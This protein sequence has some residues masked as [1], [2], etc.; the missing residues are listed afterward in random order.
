MDSDF[1]FPDS[2][3]TSFIVVILMTEGKSLDANVSLVENNARVGAMIACAYAPLAKQFKQEQSRK[4]KSQEPTVPASEETAS[5]SPDT[6][7]RSDYKARD[8]EEAKVDVNDT[9]EVLQFL[10]RK[11]ASQKTK[12]ISMTNDEL[13]AMWE[14]IHA[15]DDE[16]PAQHS[17]FAHTT[18]LESMR[19]GLELK[20]TFA[21]SE[22]M[23][24]AIFDDVLE[25]RNMI[26]ATD[27]EDTEDSDDKV[28]QNSEKESDIDDDDIRTASPKEEEHKHEHAD[29]IVFGGAVVDQIMTPLDTTQVRYSY[30]SLIGNVS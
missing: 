10:K 29:V 19:E 11:V 23:S 30:C 13:D 16:T 25:D 2:A 24:A 9:K 21:G 17:E 28:A 18:T 6:S 7:N 12:S 15:V 26:G 5:P 14:S 20:S 3:L 1:F 22:A 4:L 8:N 27:T